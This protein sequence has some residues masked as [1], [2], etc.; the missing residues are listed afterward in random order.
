L[1]HAGGACDGR[2]GTA[3][4]RVRAAL[5]AEL[6]APAGL[7]DAYRAAATIATEAAAALE[8][9][10]ARLRSTARI[11]GLAGCERPVAEHVDRVGVLSRKPDRRVARIADAAARIDGG[12]P[13]L[14]VIRVRRVVRRSAARRH[15]AIAVIARA[16]KND[17]RISAFGDRIDG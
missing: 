1:A 5:F 2:P 13:Q 15:H 12:D 10:A 9:R 4:I 3:A 14:L 6:M 7:V 8:P 16:R 11:R 17:P